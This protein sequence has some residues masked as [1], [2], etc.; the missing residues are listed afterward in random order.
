M[1][2][3]EFNPE[4]DGTTITDL[5]P[6]ELAKLGNPLVIAGREGQVARIS[7][8]MMGGDVLGWWQLGQK[9]FLDKLGCIKPGQFRKYSA[10]VHVDPSRVDE[11]VRDTY[12]KLITYLEKL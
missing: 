3:I 5:D 9:G 4:L 1:K 7:K 10:I 12:I 6:E 8:L 11:R 2:M